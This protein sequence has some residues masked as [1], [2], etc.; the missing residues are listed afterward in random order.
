MKMR[1]GVLAWCAGWAGKLREDVQI[2][3]GTLLGGL[4][5]TARKL[6]LCMPRAGERVHMKARAA[7]KTVVLR[8]SC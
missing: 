4:V 5:F 1:S 8:T 2:S 6:V 7:A 3:S